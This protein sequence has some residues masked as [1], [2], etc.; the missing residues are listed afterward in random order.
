MKQFNY[1]FVLLLFISS[2]LG[3]QDCKLKV[4]VNNLTVSEGK[5]AIGL[6]SNPESF[7]KRDSGVLGASLFIRD[8]LVEHVFYNL[9][10]GV[11]ALA[12]YH[13]ENSNGELDRSF[14][15]WPVEDYV[16]SN[17]AE[18][19][20]GPPSFEDASFNLTDSLEIEL[21]FK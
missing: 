14:L 12:V 11:Y 18:G 20:F 8:T 13:D 16:F 9:K 2:Y 10:A 7:P 17:F 21:E 6:F 4:K 15:G 5:I 3:A 1:Y 19:S